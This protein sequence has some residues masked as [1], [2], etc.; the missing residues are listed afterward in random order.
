MSAIQRELSA[1]D[2]GIPLYHAAPLADLLGR[3]TAAARFGSTLLGTFSIVALL[4]AAIGIYGVLSFVI[5]LSRRE[6]AIRLALGATVGRVIALI[7][8]QSM[9][10]VAVGLAVG[11]AG[12][13]LASGLLSTQLFGISATDPATFAVVALLVLGVAV[14][15][16]YLPS[17]TGRAHRSSARPQIRLTVDHVRWD[18]DAHRSAVRCEFFLSARSRRRPAGHTEGAVEPERKQLDGARREH[19]ARRSGWPTPGTWSSATCAP[20]DARRTIESG[21]ARLLAIGA[22]PVSLGGDHSVTYPVL[23]A[24]RPHAPKLTIIHVD[25]HPDLYDE[26]E[27]DRFSHACPFAR[28]MEEGLADR[29]VQVGIRTATGHQRAQA[30]RFGV[31]VIEMRHVRD[32]LRIAFDTPVYIS[33]DLDALDPAF[34]PGVSHRE[35]GGMSVRQLLS[36]LQSIDGTGRRR[37]SRGAEPAKRPSGGSSMVAGKV[38]RELLGVMLGRMPSRAEPGLSS[39]V[40]A[41]K[42]Q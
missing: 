34:V 38:L 37:R 24:V 10:L 28:I 13:Y 39:P 1:I 30:R 21:I 18:P 42:A 7:V 5:G 2:P 27:G 25:A 3:Q 4:L 20:A 6:I 29:L 15:A 11:L 35:P 23:R 33:V 22:R 26:F 12:A 8:T 9:R 31:E 40:Q 17:R 14:V 36:L 16:S 41:E 32:D 19:R